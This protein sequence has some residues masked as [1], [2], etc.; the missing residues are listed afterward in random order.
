[1]ALVR[2]VER[3][4]FP[5]EDEAA[6]DLLRSAAVGIDQSSWQLILSSAG[7][8]GRLELLDNPSFGWI[9]TAFVVAED[10]VLTAVH[11]ADLFINGARQFSGRAQIVFDRKS[12][13]AR[14]A[15]VHR[16]LRSVRNT[17]GASIFARA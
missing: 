11:A 7:S 9:G 2:L 16:A 13:D 5:I 1:M 14:G 10:V 12:D 8:V 17:S 4:L 3:P 6:L 15:S